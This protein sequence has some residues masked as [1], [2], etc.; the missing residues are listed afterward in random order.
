M[1]EL[2]AQVGKLAEE[3]AKGSMIKFPLFSSTH[4]GYAV[5]KEEVEEASEELENVNFSLNSIWRNVRIN[6]KETAMKHAGH[7]KDFA[8]KL[9]AE[10]IQV[11]AMSQKF[12]DSMEEKQHE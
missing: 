3:E 4:E 11:A 7:L 8:I 2:K 5:I 9:A 10:A 1:K 12:I 6:D